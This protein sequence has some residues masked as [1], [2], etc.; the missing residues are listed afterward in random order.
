MPPETVMRLGS[1]L[2]CGVGTGGEG[3]G[4]EGKGPVWNKFQ[5]SQVS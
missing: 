5:Y 3:K 1:A 2:G 4:G